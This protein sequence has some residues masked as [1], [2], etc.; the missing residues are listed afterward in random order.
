MTSSAVLSAAARRSRPRRTPLLVLIGL[1]IAAWVVLSFGRTLAALD[2]SSD[3]LE[4][5]RAEAAAL[6]T[7]IQQ[8]QAE[9]ELAQTPAFQR[10]LARAFGM[11][12]PGEQ[13]FAL[14]PE[15]GPPEPVVPLGGQHGASAGAPLE[16]WL[17]ILFGD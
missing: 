4:Q 14:E 7:R 13:A 11:G 3:R 10:M 8:G 1:L 5:I 15:A 12:L 2:E 9:M 6:E 16:A 17:E